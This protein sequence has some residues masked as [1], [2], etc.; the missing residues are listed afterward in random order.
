[1]ANGIWKHTLTMK[2]SNLSTSIQFHRSTFNIQTSQKYRKFTHSLLKC[3]N[4]DRYIQHSRCSKVYIQRV[5]HQRQWINNPIRSLRTWLSLWVSFV[6]IVFCS[7]SL[8]KAK[9]RFLWL[10]I[11]L[12]QNDCGIWCRK[13][14]IQQRTH[15]CR[16]I[17]FIFLMIKF[18]EILSTFCLSLC[19]F[20]VFRWLFCLCEFTL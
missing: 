1:M 9:G 13:F 8:L 15:R 12:W 16:T 18:R 5:W 7:C 19:D 6:F 4:L 10:W 17:S 3:H 14:C 11:S 2:V 20:F